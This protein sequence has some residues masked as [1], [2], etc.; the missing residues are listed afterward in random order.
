MQDRGHFWYRGNTMPNGKITEFDDDCKFP[1]L[2]LSQTSPR[3]PSDTRHTY[4]MQDINELS[5]DLGLKWEVTK[6]TPFSFKPT[7]IGFVWDFDVHTVTLT[8]PKRTKYITAIDEWSQSRTHSLDDTQRLH[9]K[10]L[11]ASLVIPT[12]RAY[13]TELEA[14]MGSFGSEP[15][16][17]HTP[18]HALIPDLKW[19]R[20]QLSSPC[21]AYPIPGP[22]PIFNHDAYSDA[23]SSMGIGITIG[24]HWRAW[25]LLPS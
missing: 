6:D 24:S 20:L 19:W 15:F 9:G 5:A 14:L 25:R 18:P 1:V 2:D 4:S 13:L 12:G 23:S 3:P 10:L 7:F 21:L 17:P 16:K 22:F 11:H 8:P